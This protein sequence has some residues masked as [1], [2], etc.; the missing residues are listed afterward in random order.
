MEVMV[1]GDP[2]GLKHTH[3]T[4]RGELNCIVLGVGNV[5]LVLVGRSGGES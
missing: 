3:D 5:W 4:I 1:R 2:C